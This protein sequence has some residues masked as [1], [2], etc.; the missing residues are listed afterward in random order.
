MYI[1]WIDAKEGLHYVKAVGTE[2]KVQNNGFEL[3]YKFSSLESSL[4]KTYGECR[5]LDECSGSHWCDDEDHWMRMLEEKY[6]FLQSE[7][8]T[9]AGSKLSEELNAI[10]LYVQAHSTI[11][12]SGYLGNLVLE[13]EFSNHAKVESA[14]DDVL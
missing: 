13:Y 4:E 5:R 7:W 2:L 6:R 11:I 10:F 12:G 3:R 8:N 1:A 9:E 14:D